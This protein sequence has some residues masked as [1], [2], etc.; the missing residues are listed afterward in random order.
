MYYPYL[1]GRLNELIAVRELVQNG[2]LSNKVIPIFEPIKTS[3]TLTGTLKALEDNNHPYAIILNPSVGDLRTEFDGEDSIRNTLQ[4]IGVKNAIAAYLLDDSTV[5]IPDDASHVMLIARGRDGL[6]KHMS[7]IDRN[8]PEYLVS[9]DSSRFRRMSFEQNKIRLEDHLT[10]VKSNKEYKNH[11]DEFFS[12]DHLTY[13]E[14]SYHGFSDFSIVGEPYNE[15]GFAPVTV[16]IHLVY[17]DDNEELRIHHFYSTSDNGIHDPAGK[18][19]EAMQ[20]MI[21]WLKEQQKDDIQTEGLNCL[22]TCEKTGHYPGLGAVKKYSIMHH[23]EL[24]S[25][26]LEHAEQ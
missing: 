20:Q 5:P 14:D 16:V 18:F 6:Q 24:M 9:N 11:S 17:F 2:L 13:K 7:D 26:Y 22:L 10:Q 21:R 25:R 19:D 3:A 12:D 4:D 23:L 1:R 8:S 15:G